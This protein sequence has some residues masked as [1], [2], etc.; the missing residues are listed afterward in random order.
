MVKEVYGKRFQVLV[1]VTAQRV[2]HALRGE[3]LEIIREEVGHL[4]RHK[5]PYQQRHDHGQLAKVAA[6]DHAVQEKESHHP[7]GCEIQQRVGEEEQDSPRK[8]VPRAQWVRDQS[9][10]AVSFR[11][12]ADGFKV[13]N[14]VN[15]PESG[16]A[17][18]IGNGAQEAQV[19]EHKRHK[20]LRFE[21]FLVLLVRLVF[22]GSSIPVAQHSVQSREQLRGACFCSEFRALETLA[23]G[24][25]DVGLKI[26][27]VHGVRSLRVVFAHEGAAAEAIR[28]IIIHSKRETEQVRR[29]SSKIEPR[30][31]PTARLEAIKIKL[32]ISAVVDAVPTQCAMD[33]SRRLLPVET[34]SR[35]DAVHGDTEAMD[36]LRSRG[37]GL[38]RLLC[39][40]GQRVELDCNGIRL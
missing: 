36:E 39:A 4:L 40:R 19:K 9:R 12:V 8:Q 35:L 24:K 26:F 3:R 29:K 7:G 21:F 34:R 5:D 2:N 22:R 25:H 1:Q 33:R 38:K 11:E 27:L 20:N 15:T 23:Q 31:R 28:R 18:E 6:L 30:I 10:E 17:Q 32:T 37:Q 13:E 14:Q 16:F